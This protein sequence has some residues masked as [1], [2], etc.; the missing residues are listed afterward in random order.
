MKNKISIKTVLTEETI[1][2]LKETRMVPEEFLNECIQALCMNTQPKVVNLF[3]MLLLYTEATHTKTPISLSFI[4]TDSGKKIFRYHTLHMKIVQTEVTA[5]SKQNMIVANLV[6]IF[7]K[8]GIGLSVCTEEILVCHKDSQSKNFKPCSSHQPS[9]KA[10]QPMLSETVEDFPSTDISHPERNVWGQ[11]EEFFSI[12][13]KESI[14]EK[15]PL[16]HY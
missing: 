1:A 12:P 4:Y 8:H 16:Q 2:L 15:P 14:V 3:L 7:K 13:T 5:L 10:L 11:I 6:T 9:L